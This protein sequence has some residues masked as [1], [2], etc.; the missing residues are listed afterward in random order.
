MATHSSIR[1]WRIPCTEEPGVVQSIGLHG[2]GHD[3]SKKAK[4]A[5]CMS[6]TIRLTIKFLQKP[7]FKETACVN[8]GGEMGTGGKWEQRAPLVFAKPTA[9]RCPLP[10]P[11]LCP[12]PWRALPRSR[13]R[14]SPYRSAPIR[15][16]PPVTGQTY[17]DSTA[18][19]R[20]A[21]ANL[22]SLPPHFHLLSK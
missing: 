11:L 21:Q 12:G 5:A 15:P 7:F 18:G 10:L 4:A 14:P 17:P 22:L 8:V 16:W 19:R 2:V 6:S 3:L 1:A 13:A 20:Q 9:P